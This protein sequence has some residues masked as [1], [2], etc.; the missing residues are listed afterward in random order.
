MIFLSIYRLLY[1]AVKPIRTRLKPAV[2][3]ATPPFRFCA[4]FSVPLQEIPP[5]YTALQDPSLIGLIVAI[6]AL[7]AVSVLI[8]MSKRGSL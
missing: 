7:I 1:D 2:D 4:L 6:G 8:S 5:N 3:R